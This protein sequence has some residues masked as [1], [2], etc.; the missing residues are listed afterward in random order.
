MKNIYKVKGNIFITSDE[1]IKDCYVLTDLDKI[2][3]VDE[4]NEEQWHEFN[5]E[6][7]ILTT[8]EQ[9]ISDGVQSIDKPFLIWLINNPNCEEVQVYYD[10]IEFEF[11]KHSPRKKYIIII[12]KEKHKRKIDTCYNF[13]KEIGCVQ[14]D[15]RC[16]KEESKFEKSIENTI[17]FM[18]IANAM[19]SKKEEPK[20][21]T[22]EE[23]PKQGIDIQE[24]E[25]KANEIIAN[26]GKKEAEEKTF[27]FQEKLVEYF[28][29]TP[30]EKILE[31]WDK[32]VEYDKIGPTMEEFLESK[33][34]YK[35]MSKKFTEILT[36][37]PDDVLIKY[38]QQETL[39]VK[40]N[41]EKHLL[42]KT[43]G[44]KLWCNIIQRCY[45]PKNH[46][47]KYYGEKGVIMEDYF[48]NSYE[49]FINWIKGIAH[50]NEWLNS[51]ELSLDRIDNTLGYSR[52][53]IKFSTKTEQVE[54]QNLRIDNKSG[55]KGVCYHKLNKKY[56]A[57]ITINKSKV[58]LGYYDTALEAALVYD[59]YVLKSNLNRKTNL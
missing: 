19:F 13:N 16:E 4:S 10:L 45:N 51:S 31:D 42:T 8:D 21:Y 6:K 7:I 37:I 57:T 2:I 53:N 36:I 12:P 40:R 30:R 52:G 14:L 47:Y 59:N 20:Q 24:F 56:G 25:K 34:D 58:F 23:E 32:S 46:S 3:K 55:Y 41:Y 54:N 22:S 27:N 49:N 26:V 38:T 33:Q 35:K 1:D 29:N 44:Y 28:N 9:L 48:K 5:C 43:K 15:C 11:E 50:Y 39:E 17:N 18:N